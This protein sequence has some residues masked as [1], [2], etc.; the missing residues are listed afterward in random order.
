[1]RLLW[2]MA[3][4]LVG[5]DAAA[6]PTEGKAAV[7]FKQPHRDYTRM[8]GE[9]EIYCESALVEG[10]RTLA[11]RAAKKLS[12]SLQDVIGAV[13]AHARGELRS[14]RYYL[15]WGD[16]SPLGGLKSGMRYVR[17]GE[18]ERSATHDP[19]WQHA[20]I[21]YSAENLMYLDG[22]WS[23]KALLHELAHA[24]HVTRWPERH[25]P[26]HQAWQNAVDRGL[27]RDVVD[28]KGRKIASAY[29][30]TN[31]LE[32]FAEMSAA[33]FVGINYFPFDRRGLKAHDPQGHAL[34]ESLW[35]IR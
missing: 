13:P 22:L 2:L 24:W 1:M 11:E 3:M 16:R 29:A 6:A 34:V 20:V 18:A 27:Y 8:A 21:V 17:R 35:S 9:F 4:V 32:Y 15:M 28:H 33:Y 12:S 25:P 31:S 5:G 30:E 10:D 7:S 19:R 26:I 14:L 23:K